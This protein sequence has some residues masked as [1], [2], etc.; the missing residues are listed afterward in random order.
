MLEPS[1]QSNPRNFLVYLEP[2]PYIH[3]ISFLEKRRDLAC[4]VK[5]SAVGVTKTRA[6]MR[7]S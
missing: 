7:Q 5:A 4:R 3:K 2:A 6:C 1:T